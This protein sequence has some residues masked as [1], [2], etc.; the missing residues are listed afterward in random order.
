M[1]DKKS[2]F[3][4]GERSIYKADPKDPFCLKIVNKKGDSDNNKVWDNSKVLR[5]E[6]VNVNNTFTSYMSDSVR[7]FGE[8][9]DFM[10]II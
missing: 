9:R 3:N 4:F 10:S 7:E 8:T 2:D 1:E 5:I 6:V